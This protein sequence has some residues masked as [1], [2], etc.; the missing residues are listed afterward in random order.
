MKLTGT[1]FGREFKRKSALRPHVA[2][3]D[4]STVINLGSYARK[5]DAV[6][7]GSIGMK[8]LV[9]AGYGEEE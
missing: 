3:R 6:E 1:Y 8:P 2:K 4:K 9:K 7:N 5:R